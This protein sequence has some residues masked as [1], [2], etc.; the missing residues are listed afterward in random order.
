MKS[1]KRIFASLSALALL[2]ISPIS[3]SAVT[4]P[5]VV[6][7]G[8]TAGSMTFQGTYTTVTTT[9]GDSGAYYDN[10]TSPIFF[11]T[12]A[13]NSYS[14]AWVKWSF[15]SPVSQV[16]VYY[17]HVESTA[18][19]NNSGNN[20]PQKWVTN[21]GNVNLALVADGGDR[22]ASGGDVVTGQPEA[23]YSGNVANCLPTAGTACSGYIDLVFPTGIT[24]IKT[25]NS[26]TGAGPGYNG[27]G[28][29]LD[30][31]EAGP[32]ESD[33]LANTGS[34]EIPFYLGVTALLG[35]ITLS[36]LSAMRSRRRSQ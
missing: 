19:G 31:T 35:G 8:L 3:A 9:L 18:Y 29:A 2:T 24:W 34:S 23:S 7:N 36:V 26:A 4:T 6:D 21:R 14:G 22:V 33:P 5:E 12:D 20:D 27:V 25:Q 30:A 15:S 16:R 17:A 11:A 13:S 32:T 28:L 1:T 10:G